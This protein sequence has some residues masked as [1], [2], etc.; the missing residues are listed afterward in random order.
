MPIQLAPVAGIAL[1]YGAVALLAYTASRY[2]LPG[3]RDQRVED[4]MDETPEGLTL[5]RDPEQMNASA[6]W[7][8]VYRI[9][10]RGPGVE[11][12]ATGFARIKVR[13]LK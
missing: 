3:R 1:Q 2:A 9:G 13:R 5:R 7:R 4:A 12:D 8:R 10:R 11:I 6:R